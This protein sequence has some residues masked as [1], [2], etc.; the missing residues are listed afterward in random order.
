MIEVSTTELRNFLVKKFPGHIVDDVPIKGTYGQ[1]W[2]ISDKMRPEWGF[3]I[4]TLPPEKLVDPDSLNDMDYLKREFRMWLELPRHLNVVPA[5]GFDIVPFSLQN[6]DTPVRL[7]IMRM[8][9]LQGSLE[10]WVNDPSYSME[11]RLIALAQSFNGLMHLYKHG[12]EGHG[13][14]KPNNI[15]YSDL[16]KRFSLSE[17]KYWPGPDHPWLIRI[18]DLGWADAWIDLGFSNKALRQYL[19]PE[20]LEG[21]FVSRQSDM[22]SMGVIIAEL[23]QFTSPASNLKKAIKSEG[24]W[25]RCVQ[26]GDWNLSQ[27]KSARIERLIRCCLD[28]YPARRPTPD[29]CF[30]EICIELQE[31][32]DHDIKPTIQLWN[33]QSLP[34]DDLEH[35]AWAAGQSTRLGDKEA[36]RS[37]EKL[38]RQIEEIVADDF[39]KCKCW[40]ELARP[41]IKLLQFEQSEDSA[42]KIACLRQQAQTLLVQRLGQMNQCE[43]DSMPIPEDMPKAIRK[44]EIFSEV[45]GYL[46]EVSDIKYQTV[47]ADPVMMGPM[48]LA[49]LAFSYAGKA[50]SSGNEDEANQFLTEA[51]KNAPNESTLYYFRA[52]W[53]FIRRFLLFAADKSG[54]KPS[55]HELAGWV[56]DLEN[57]IKHSPDWEEPKSLLSSLRQRFM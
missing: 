1:I 46:A 32:Y 31:V 27:I 10:D 48:G 41:L 3:A 47:V 40:V 11:D 4:K 52:Y 35:F 22:F 25:K 19:A 6:N 50:H 28:F 43:L 24:N 37:R 7:P 18:A 45:V 42:L 5:L 30:G 36:K 21:R 8:P 9:R 54:S 2:L 29:E 44:F 55:V 20:R 14:L 53:S 33:N 13:D 15:L 16:R 57:A 26:N 56:S 38:E 12:F 23:L 39:E 49:A 34:I 51:I 17:S